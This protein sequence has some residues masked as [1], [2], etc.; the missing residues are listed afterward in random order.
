VGPRAR[1]CCPSSMSPGRGGR[2]ACGELVRPG[3]PGFDGDKQLPT[4]AFPRVALSP[5]ERGAA[6][7]KALL[8]GVRPRDEVGKT[9]RRIAAELV[10]D[11]ERVYQRKKATNRELLA[12]LKATGTTLTQLNG[13]GPSAAARL[14]VEVGD[15]SRF[16]DRNHF[17]SWNG[18]A[19]ID[20][21]SSEH[22]R[23]RLSRAGNRQIN[24]AM[25]IMAIVQLRN[26]TE[27]RAYFDRRKAA[28]EDLHGSHAQP[29]AGSPTSGIAPCSTAPSLL[30]R[31]REGN[32]ATT[33]TPARLA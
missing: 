14:L 17:A 25:H 19:P 8:A 1:L 22:T 21:S 2:G 26:P 33:L 12:L 27:G 28:R 15:I 4:G 6:Q 11:L 16:P 9:R 7:A 18:T 23:Q 5:S 3:F 31:A 10:A 30:E 20:A 13:I 24:R 29:H 32:G